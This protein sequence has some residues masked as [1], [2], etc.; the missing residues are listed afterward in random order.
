MQTEVQVQQ[1]RE[2]YNRIKAEVQKRIV[3]QDEIIEGALL[4]LLADGHALLEGV[5]G[6][7][8]TQLVHTLSEVLSLSFSRIQFTP[9]MMPSDI[10]GTML[11]IENAQGRKQFEFQKGPIFAQIVLAD[12]I[13]RATP[14]TQ[15]ALLEAM[16]ER[17]VSVARTSHKLD[18]PFCVLAT[19][20]P[21]ELEGTYPLPEAQLDRFLF[22]LHVNYPDADEMLEIM[23]R[24]TRDGDVPIERVIDSETI[25]WMRQMV[26]RVPIVEH[27]ERYIIALIRATHSDNPDAPEITKQYVEL[28][29]SIRGVQAVTLTAKIKALL[30]ERY[31]VAFEDVQAVA[32]PA[33]RH[34]IFLNYEGKGEDIKTDEIVTSILESLDAE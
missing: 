11:L 22:K 24:T 9:D 32:L 5:P 1:F 4:C 13:N 26:R 15:S 25:Q 17:T 19:Q 14:R 21:L 12:E 8:K 33:L 6:L 16:Q 18:E 7:G 23:R 10:T 30:D 20:N 28:G 27:V 29:G 3:G 31:N 2:N 34:R